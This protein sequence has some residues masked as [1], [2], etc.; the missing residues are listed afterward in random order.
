MIS[1]SIDW[2]II[3]IKWILLLLQITNQEIKNLIGRMLMFH[4]YSSFHIV[5]ME[6]QSISMYLVGM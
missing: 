3:F 6:T 1:V 4:S 5:K 2:F